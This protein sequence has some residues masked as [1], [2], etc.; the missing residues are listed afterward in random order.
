MVF[1]PLRKALRPALF[2]FAVVFLSSP[3]YPSDVLIIGDTHYRPVSQVADGIKHLLRARVKIYN[4]ADVSGRLPSVVSKEDARVVVALGKDA[5]NEALRLPVAVPVIYGLIIEPP[6][7][8]RGNM[9]GVYMSTPVSEYVHIVRKYLPVLKKIAVMGSN[10][11]MNILDG[12]VSPNVSVF[13]TGNSAEFLGALGRI[14][15]A[16]ALLLLPDVSILS[17]SVMENVYLFSYRKGIPLLGISEGN[18]KQGSLLAL[19]FDPSGISEQIS[20][21]AGHV[22]QG[23]D[24]AGMRPAAP[25]KYRLS[26]NINTARKMGIVIP[27]GLL[28]DADKI[29][30]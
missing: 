19:V 23:S 25:K 1:M 29:Y 16:Q 7:R 6:R 13:R 26:L 10:R 4:L 9:T 14:G 21:I 5:V 11:L 3:A 24:L 12:T 15:D 8:H 30:E 27:E 2:L 20:E 22:L 18:V 17:A 28:R